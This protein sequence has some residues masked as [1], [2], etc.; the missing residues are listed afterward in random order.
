M[1]T[2]LKKIDGL[3]VKI[4]SKLTDPF[5]LAVRLYWGWQFFIAGKGKL[6]DITRVTEFFTSLGI[7]F[8]H[9]NAV[10]VGGL[11]CFGGLLLL[12]GLFSRWITAPLIINMC[13]AYLTA[14]REVVVNI[15]NNSDDF[16]SA[17]PFLFLMASLIVFIFGPGKI[18]LDALCGRCCH[19][20]T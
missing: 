7:P 1:K 4:G 9:A 5:L 19:K 15:F 12:A 6:M 13:V 11:E 16:V 18:S 2:L 20:K 17:A 3:L 14:H 8:P 10:F